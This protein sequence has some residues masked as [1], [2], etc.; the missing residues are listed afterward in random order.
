VVEIGHAQAEAVT[1]IAAA[2][3]F[4]AVLHRDLAGRPRALEMRRSA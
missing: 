1:A 3:G 2:A 4:A